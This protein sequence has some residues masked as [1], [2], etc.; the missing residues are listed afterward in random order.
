[1]V[2]VQ[3]QIFFRIILFEGAKLKEVVVFSLIL[4]T[5]LK[6][7][8]HFASLLPKVAEDLRAHGCKNVIIETIKDSRH[9]VADE[10]PE[11]VAD[12]IERCASAK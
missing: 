11:S 1:L 9:Y 5:P 6:A 3:I 2:L 8:K 12:L 4:K 10:Q 7:D